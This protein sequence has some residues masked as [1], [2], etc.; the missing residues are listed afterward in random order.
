MFII[1]VILN[2]RIGAEQKRTNL[3]PN[4]Y[5]TRKIIIIVQP[6]HA[7]VGNWRI[8]HILSFITPNHITCGGGGPSSHACILF[9]TWCCC[10]GWAHKTQT[11]KRA[12]SQCQVHHLTT[13]N[14][15]SAW[16]SFWKHIEKNIFCTEF[17]IILSFIHLYFFKI[18]FPAFTAFCLQ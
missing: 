11:Q 1:I 3:R 2:R 8:F 5:T 14:R 6:R 7:F 10:T 12:P 16:R 15:I 13:K 18:S 4:N 17:F 9:C